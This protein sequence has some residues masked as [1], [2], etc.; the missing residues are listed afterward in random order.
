MGL[1]PEESQTPQQRGR[2]LDPIF[3]DRLPVTVQVMTMW[4][5][6]SKP[7]QQQLEAWTH[8]PD[9]GRRSSHQHQPLGDRCHLPVS[10]PTNRRPPGGCPY[11]CRQS[12]Q[13][14]LGHE[15][16]RQSAYT[17]PTHWLPRGLGS[18]PVR[19]KIGEQCPRHSKP[20]RHRDSQEG[21]HLKSSQVKPLT[22]VPPRRTT[23][24]PVQAGEPGAEMDIGNIRIN[25]GSGESQQ[26]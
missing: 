16:P 4:N 12:H 2:Q 26:G 23:T 13:K 17:N 22:S 19:S 10:Q 5:F 1:T 18:S 8:R 11:T 3:P 20:P 6:W 7:D 21:P 9:V 25:H 15:P 14:G 24:L